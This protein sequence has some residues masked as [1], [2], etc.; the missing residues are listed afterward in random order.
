MPSFQIVVL[1]GDGIGPEVTAE[2]VRVLRA[3]E[4]QLAGVSFDLAEHPC[5]AAEHLRSGSPLADATMHACRH[6][7]AI[8]LGA[9]GLPEVRWP[10]GTEMAPQLDLREELELYAG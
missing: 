1:P 9:M 8:L 4:K 6:G 10:G 3:V 2:A 7:D 5:G